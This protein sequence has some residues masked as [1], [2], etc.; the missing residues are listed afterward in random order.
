MPQYRIRK[1]IET[2]LIVDC[3]NEEKAQ[4]WANQIHSIIENEDGEPI[5]EDEFIYFNT[6]SVPA[7]IELDTENLI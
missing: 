2:E 4:E 6:D 5:S 1:V 7:I 3:E